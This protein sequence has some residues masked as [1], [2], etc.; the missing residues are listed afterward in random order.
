MR[1]LAGLLYAVS[2]IAVAQIPPWWQCAPARAEDPLWRMLARQESS[3]SRT[4][5]GQTYRIPVTGLRIGTARELAAAVQSNYETAPILVARLLEPAGFWLIG[6]SGV[7]L[8]KSQSQAT[9]AMDGFLASRRQHTDLGDLVMRAWKEMR[10]PPESRIV[11]AGHSLGGME[12][13][14]LVLHPVHGAR[15]QSQVNRI[16]TF[17]A[18]ALRYLSIDARDIRRFMHTNDYVLGLLRKYVPGSTS[19][20]SERLLIQSFYSGPNADPHNAY[21]DNRAWDGFDGF[22]DRGG[23]RRMVIDTRVMWRCRADRAALAFPLEEIP[24]VTASP[25]GM[26]FIQKAPDQSGSMEAVWPDAP[27]ATRT[28]RFSSELWSPAGTRQRTRTA[29][30]EGIY[31]RRG[32]APDRDPLTFQPPY[33]AARMSVDAMR[34]AG[35][36]TPSFVRLANI[37]EP[38]TRAQIDQ[39]SS[40]PR[41]REILVRI[42]TELHAESY[43]IET[44]KTMD[45]GLWMQAR[46]L[47]YGRP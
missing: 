37:V 10:I 46:I 15:V 23:A 25:R 12:A 5:L 20:V 28:F 26:P 17:G 34:A 31:I 2:G 22:G 14:N 11:L 45:G 38:R 33:S 1:R 4:V 40:T 8:Y 32:N 41:M 43:Q 7:Q 30:F 27:A 13:E 47:S 18:P 9:T 3:E 21:Q 36:T 42:L 19:K 6:V 35:L 16:V 29:G 24:K 44:G 39:G